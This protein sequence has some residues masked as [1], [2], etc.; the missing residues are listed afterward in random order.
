MDF[1]VENGYFDRDRVIRKARFSMLESQV[2][3]TI[4]LELFGCSRLNV[5]FEM[6]R[7]RLEQNWEMVC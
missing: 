1:C 7:R 4:L 6:P 5:E 2:S 3:R